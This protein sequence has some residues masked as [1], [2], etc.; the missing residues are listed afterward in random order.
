MIFEDIPCDKL[1]GRPLWSILRMN[2]EEHVREPGAK[3]GSIGMVMAGRLRCVDVLAAR[4][5]YFH[6][7]FS[8]NI[9]KTNGQARLVITVHLENII[10][11]VYLLEDREQHCP[12]LSDAES[13]TGLPLGSSQSH[14]EAI[15]PPSSSIHGWWECSG[16]VW[17]RRASQLPAL[18]CRAHESHLASRHLWNK[19]DGLGNQTHEL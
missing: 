18:W 19:S 9:R 7:G 17:G 14:P 8:G 16:H 15:C 1:L 10:C 4:T 11:R 12:W 3:V 5:V 2:G 6:H 13:F